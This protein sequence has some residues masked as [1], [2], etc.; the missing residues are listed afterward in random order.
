MADYRTVEDY[1]EEIQRYSRQNFMTLYPSPVLLMRNP[2]SV[3]QPAKLGPAGFMT[4]AQV[5][6]TIPA[7]PLVVTNDYLVV[8]VVK[9]EGH[10]FPDRI[11]VGRTKSTDIN[12]NDRDVSK[13]H[14]YF[15]DSGGKWSFTDAG[16][17]N[18][19]FIRGQRLAQNVKTAIEDGTDIS[20][21]AGRYRF[22]TAAGFYEFLK[23]GPTNS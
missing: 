11:G 13:Y 5:A 18:G 14:G 12:L 22:Y 21:G 17:S 1:R 20:L 23:Q 16:S 7:A 19:T 8:P 10:P 6:P 15:S 2:A 3:P 4:R 9:V